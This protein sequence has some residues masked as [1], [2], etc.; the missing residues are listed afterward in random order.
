MTV[1]S[2]GNQVS[3]VISGVSP[4]S[5]VLKPAPTPAPSPVVN[6][7]KCESLVSTPAAQG[8]VG[9]PGPQGIP[10]VQGTSGLIEGEE[11]VYS[12]RVDFI[13]D[14]LLY[15]GDATIGSLT[16]APVWRIR[17][18]S[19]ASLDGDVTEI[20]AGGSALFDKVWDNRLNLTY[21]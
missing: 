5:T 3:K 15:K 18:I 2:T 16:S 20:W 10:G 8:P 14:N 1:I 9:P 19:I 7:N 17:Q 13:S 6:S 12:K 4:Y 21:S 11:I